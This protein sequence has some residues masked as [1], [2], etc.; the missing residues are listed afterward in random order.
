MVKA[1]ALHGEED[2]DLGGFYLMNMQ[3]RPYK[4]LPMVTH[5]YTQI[6]RVYGNT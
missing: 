4:S 6:K 2:E 1:E 3:P 5:V